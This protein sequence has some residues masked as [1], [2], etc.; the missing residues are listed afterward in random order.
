MN[1]CSGFNM[2]VFS[3]ERVVNSYDYL[4]KEFVDTNRL[5]SGVL[6]SFKK[7]SFKILYELCDLINQRQMDYDNRV[8][9]EIFVESVLQDDDYLAKIRE[10]N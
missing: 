4:M 5:D 10:R 2:D 3:L 1:W 8:F 9:F 6:M 7:C